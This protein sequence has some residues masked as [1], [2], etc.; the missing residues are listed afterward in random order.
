VT[1]CDFVVYIL[2]I[3]DASRAAHKK[4]VFCFYALEIDAFHPW[5]FL[6]HP[7]RDSTAYFH[8]FF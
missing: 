8:H 6:S 5:F 1:K 4:I 7:S 3:D 2:K